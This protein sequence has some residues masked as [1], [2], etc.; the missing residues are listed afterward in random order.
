MDNRINKN[1]SP[2][3][4]CDTRNNRIGNCLIINCLTIQ[5]Y[6]TLIANTPAL[7]AFYK[8]GGLDRILLIGDGLGLMHAI[9]YSERTLAL[10]IP[11]RCVLAV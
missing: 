4:V 8:E 2:I 3:D 10:D 5:A 7:K 9:E 11:L 1:F 6:K